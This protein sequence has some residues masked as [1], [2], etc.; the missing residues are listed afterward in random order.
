MGRLV[1]PGLCQALQGVLASECCR[2]EGQGWSGQGVAVE[3][4][5]HTSDDLGG[6]DGSETCRLRW[7]S[8]LCSVDQLAIAQR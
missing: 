6:S 8:K 7:E 4:V 2:R 1:G 5:P 3:T